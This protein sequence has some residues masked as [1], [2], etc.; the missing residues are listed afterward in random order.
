MKVFIK[1]LQ[2]IWL[3]TGVTCLAFGIILFK[4]K[5]FSSEIILFASM[6]VISVIMFIVNKK[7]Y[8][9]HPGNQS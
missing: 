6:V 1:I 7:R 8:K 5:G 4:N 2:Y 3:L 9:D